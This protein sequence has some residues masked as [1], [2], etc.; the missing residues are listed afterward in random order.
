MTVKINSELCKTYNGSILVIDDDPLTLHALSKILRKFEFRVVKCE[1]AVKAM[2][3]FSDTGFDAVLTD[4]IMPEISGLEFVDIIRRMNTEVPV[5]LMTGHLDMDL[6]VDAVKRG[7]FDFIYKPCKPALVCDAVMK[8]VKHY[9]Y[10]QEEKQSKIE[11]DQKHIAELN[12]ANA[13]LCAA[14]DRADSAMRAKSEF[15]SNLSHEIRTPMNGII[16]MTELI[17]DTGLTKEQKECA[18]MIFE[19]SNYL[20][21]LLI[22]LLDYTKIEARRMNI[23]ESVFNLSVKLESILEPFIAQLRNKKLTIQFHI[24]P[25]L[26]AMLKGCEGY[27]SRVLIHLIGN[28]VKFTEKG[29]ISVN[30]GLLNSEN[31]TDDFE[32]DHGRTVSFLQF[33]VSDTGI[34]I[35]P[36]KLESIFESFTQADGSYTREYGGTGLGLSISREFVN[37]LGGNIWVESEEGRGSKFHFTAKFTT[38]NKLRTQ[39]LPAHKNLLNKKPSGKPH[40]EEKIYLLDNQTL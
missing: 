35:P 4:I 7:A 30:V 17:L 23:E 32:E 33:T 18:E 9:K 5:I 20:N 14:K 38:P 8:A 13:L 37:M 21:G 6:A 28:A 19:S 11:L 2:S 26:P 36:D 34:G 24:N 31:G 27:F 29:C 15:L 1:N 12:L 25:D 10:L 3:I 39:V 40:S 22:D 16:G